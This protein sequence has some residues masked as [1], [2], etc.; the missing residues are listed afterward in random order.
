MPWSRKRSFLI[1]IKRTFNQGCHSFLRG[2]AVHLSKQ[3]SKYAGYKED[4]EDDD[5]EEDDD[6]KDGED[7][8]EDGS[9]WEACG[10]VTVFDWNCNAMFIFDYHKANDDRAVRGTYFD[11]SRRIKGMTF[12][13]LLFA[14]V[15]RN[16][17]DTFVPTRAT[18]YL[19]VSF[20]C[21]GVL[22]MS[23]HLFMFS[24]LVLCYS[25]VCEACY[26]HDCPP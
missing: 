7:R 11:E 12:R 24:C 1:K 15:T 25:V 23:Y 16:Y 3:A 19:A 4:A 10:S 21:E 9:K 8:V 14:F 5:D 26:F 2:N 18:S 20:D 22:D 6:E 13:R 17:T